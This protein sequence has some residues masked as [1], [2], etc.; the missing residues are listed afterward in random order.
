M[1][2]TDYSHGPSAEEELVYSF[3][4]RIA[5]FVG[6]RLH[7][8]S[9]IQDITQDVLLAVMLALRRG[10]LRDPDRLGAF[11]FGTARNIINSYRRAGSRVPPQAP[12][13]SEDCSVTDIDPVEHAERN[14][15]VRRALSLLDSRDRRILL[16]TLVNGLKAGEVAVRIGLTSEVVRARKS[17][18]LKKMI[19]LV[20][21]LSQRSRTTTEPI[22]VT[23]WTGNRATPKPTA[24]R[25]V[26]DR[27]GRPDPLLPTAGEPATTGA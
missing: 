1:N 23:R 15:L 2:A 20:G 27:S 19:E 16:L 13:D 5:L 22:V 4:N 26:G 21:T 8:R 12:I 14:A 3:R 18:A 7:D 11:V 17:R 10:Q 24:A 9:A 6:T 25:V